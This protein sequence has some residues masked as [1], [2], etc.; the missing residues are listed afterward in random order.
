MNS[1][2]NRFV[3]LTAL[4][5]VAGCHSAPPKPA[6]PQPMPM[7]GGMSMPAKAAMIERLRKR[8]QGGGNPPEHK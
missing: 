5:L 1:K 4:V 7:M 6:A 8:A 3:S 2:S